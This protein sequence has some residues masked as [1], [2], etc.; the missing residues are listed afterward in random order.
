[1]F[2]IYL[3]ENNVECEIMTTDQNSKYLKI[4]LANNGMRLFRVEVSF[5]NCKCS[6]TPYCAHIPFQK[7][8]A[9]YGRPNPIL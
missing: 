1:M 6:K 4:C 8:S 2:F 5:S 3:S 9:F 7:I